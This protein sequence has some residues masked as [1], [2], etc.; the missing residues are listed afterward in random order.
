MSVE[1]P[2]WETLPVEFKDRKPLIVFF[3]ADETF[4][5]E[6]LL[7]RGSIQDLFTAAFLCLKK[8][9]DKSTAINGSW[10]DSDSPNTPKKEGHYEA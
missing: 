3:P 6:L 1:K 10:G 9:F 4:T 5:S 8:A 2:W 7:S